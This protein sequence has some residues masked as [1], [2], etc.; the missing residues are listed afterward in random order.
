MPVTLFIYYFFMEGIYVMIR[1]G[2]I[3]ILKIKLSAK[4]ENMPAS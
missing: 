1:N 2:K 3:F 4:Q